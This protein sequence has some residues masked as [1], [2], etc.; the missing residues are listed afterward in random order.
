M[1]TN[2]ETSYELRHLPTVV[3]QIKTLAEQAD[4]R[5]IRPQ[6]VAAL[7]SA[8]E[9]L[10]THPNRWGDPEYNLKKPGG[11]MYHGIISPVNYAVYE[12]EKIVLIT[13]IRWLAN[14]EGK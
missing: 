14:V 9:E 7:R 3:Q 11:C 13:S 8:L 6:L 2:G 10:R 4:A 1:P 5:G 12:H